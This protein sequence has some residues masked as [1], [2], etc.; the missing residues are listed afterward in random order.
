[1]SKPEAVIEIGATGIRLLV[2]ELIE[3]KRNILDRSEL[4]ITI[5]RD[6]FSEGVISRETLVQILKI[7]KRFSE[8]LKGW[9]ITPEKTT[10]IATSAFRE[11]KNKDPILDRILSSTGFKV[12]VIDGIEEN[13][14]TYIA[15]KECLKEFPLEKEEDTIILEVSGGSTEMMLMKK[16]KM[17]GAHSLR[18]GSARVEKNHF[19]RSSEDILRYISEF[20]QNTKGSLE[21]EL[22]FSDVKQFITVG[23]VLNV[24]AVH[25]GKPIST[26]L[27]SISRK[28]FEKFTDEIQKYSVDELVARF[29]ISYS[30]AQ[31]M[32]VS[33]L[34][35]KM[36][37]KLTKVKSIIVPETNIREGL[38]IDR[39]SKSN[40]ELKNEFND[41][42]IASSSNLLKKYY[43]DEKH[44][45]Y[46]RTVSL[47]LFNALKSETTFDDR[48]K[49]LL[50][51]AA[52]L[53]D[54][55]IFIRLDHHNLHGEYIIKN[56][57]IFGLS[58]M[59]NTIISQIAKYHR[60]KKSPQDS[61]SFQNLPR[62]ERMTI[63]KLTAIIRVAD[64]L[65]RSHSQKLNDLSF[66][67]SNDTLTI[68]TKN[69]Q[70][71]SLEKVALS[72][73]GDFFESIFGLKI[74]LI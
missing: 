4:P 41:Q 35:Y 20:I 47:Q 23:S 34:I 55:G 71:I 37:I 1:M 67:I 15:V 11:A 72:Q 33:L 49:L 19:S 24:A 63:L 73:K 21:S 36:F 13:R 57:E 17:A 31:T 12:N 22:N 27:W 65:D 54:I 26:F 52:I 39:T 40:S 16:G 7:L 51:V 64:A 46:V 50:Q 69:H 18:F 74:I 44:A 14:L 43:G 8:Q 29:K 10:V 56:S 53:H 61:E 2:A 9:G 68:K 45:E 30:D 62:A 70:N 3:S 5:G 66:H 25:I 58:K 38:I 42:V 59:E 48:S 60:G 32:H 6:V 28:D